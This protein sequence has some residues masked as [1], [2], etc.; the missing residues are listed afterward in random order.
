MNKV[1][2]SVSPVNQ[3]QR[4]VSIDVLRGFALLGILMVNIQSFGL[5]GAK[6]MNP[7][8]VGDLEG[9]SYWAWWVTHTFFDSKFMTIFSLLFGAGIVLMWERSVKSGRKFTGLHYRRT[10]WLLLIGLAHAHLL[11]SGDILFLYG[12][13]AMVVYWLCGLSPRLLIAIGFSLLLIGS[14]IS[15]ASQLGVSTD[16]K[17]A[18]EMK[19]DWEPSEERVESEIAAFR[20]SWFEQ[21][22]YRRP[23]AIFMQTF[24][25]GF[26]GFWRAGGLMLVG[27]G[28]FKLGVFNAQRSSQFYVKGAIIGL[29]LGMLVIQSGV[30]L[31]EY[32][33]WSFEYSFFA[34][35]QFN[36]WGSLFLS[37]GYICLVMLA[38]QK[39]VLGWLRKSLAAVGQMALTN[40]LMQ[41]IICT[42][43]FYGHGFGWFET[44]SRLELVGVVLSVW[45]LQ[46]IASPAWLKHFRFG[47]FEWLWRSLSYWKLQPIARKLKTAQ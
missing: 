14:L 29:L 9:S 7:M 12:I 3:T 46:M 8:A 17:M 18:A 32:N 27:M 31:L 2:E 44:M 1:P 42:T 25:I 21:N 34:G 20:G 11:W 45:L 40:Y 16:P 19:P 41:T 28:L 15:L 5:I 35:L 22:E 4:F 33:Q 38:C 10:F 43:L 39:E 13:C 23:A 36:Y 30:L 47:P 26:W 37:F 6:Y 24:L